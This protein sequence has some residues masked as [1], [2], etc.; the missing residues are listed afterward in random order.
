MAL[1]IYDEFEKKYIGK[2]V[3]YD[4]VAG[5][6]CVDLFDQYLK[7]CFNITGVW[8]N[9]AK[10]L[11]NNFSS[12]PALVKAFD[13]IENTRD[14]IVKKGDVV[15][16]GGGSWGHVGIG[17]GKGD[18]DYFISLEENTLGRH[19]PT[20][21]VKHYFNG[22]GGNDGCNPVLGVL[23][24]KTEQSQ[25][26]KIVINGIDVSMHQG[27]I[28]FTKVKKSGVKFVII[29][30][31]NW[32]REKNCVEKDPYFEQNYKNAKAAGFDI[33]VYYF[34]W[35]CSV[36]GAMRDAELCLNYIRD[37]KFEY[38]IY[39]DLEWDK[40]FAQGRQVCD[41][42]VRAFCDKLEDSGYFSGLYISR[43]P[44]QTYI[45]SNVANRYSLWLAEYNS[46]CNY[47][48]NYG[49]WQYSSTGRV[50][51]ING[52]VDMDYCYVD[53]P[54]IIKNAGLNGYKKPEPT[55]QPTPTPEK[56]ELDTS[57]YKEGDK[58]YQA[59][60]LKTL[61]KLAI[62]KGMVSGKL[63]DTTGLG[64]GS[65]KVVN[66]LLKKWGYKENGI[67]GTNFINRLYK[68]L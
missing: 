58:G 18:K 22:V 47:D 19:E 48:G 49:M 2:A 61:L 67:A 25:S 53:Y 35:E 36:S 38:P 14:L 30:C 21:L 62:D 54:T 63:D 44:L 65:I 45:S 60:A 6:Q 34:T 7:D 3:D 39:F 29:R 51:G 10:D 5:V 46:K 64:G 43:I 57:G 15:I 59:L 23:R 32:N 56:K 33:G 50:S 37:K 41:G 27:E 16:W 8:C 20:Q 52:D 12:Y 1:M 40:A 4:G 11:Y 17:N 24:P 28:D 55:P 26:K 68:E 31:N 13:R 42:M 9:G 66:A